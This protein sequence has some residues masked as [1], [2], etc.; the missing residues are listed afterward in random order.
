MPATLL[1]LL[2]LCATAY[3]S[4]TSHP[5][6][7][8]MPSH[9]TLP[10]SESSAVERTRLVAGSL[11]TAC[12]SESTGSAG[13]SAH[14]Q[15]R[16]LRFFSRAFS[17]AVAACNVS[18]PKPRL[19]YAR[20]CS[21]SRRLSLPLELLLDTAPDAAAASAAVFALSLSRWIICVLSSPRAAAVRSVC[22]SNA[23]R[24]ALAASTELRARVRFTP[25][26]AG[27]PSAVA[28]EVVGEDDK[29]AAAPPSSSF[30]AAGCV[31]KSVLLSS[32]FLL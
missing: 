31:S 18:S 14:L 32:C 6:A 5:P 20:L 26:T 29:A 28:E 17:R 2:R 12:R 4:S 15:Y 22:L 11:P 7:A 19:T 25:S 13:I 9:S 8:T 21:T 10:I 27:T 1:L 30:T 16:S 24:A 3:L 23:C